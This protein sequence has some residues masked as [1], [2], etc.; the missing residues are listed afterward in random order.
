[1]H[2]GLLGSPFIN[3]VAYLLPATFSNTSGQIL[4]PSSVIISSRVSPSGTAVGLGS[5][6]AV[7][8]GF[9]V[10][11]GVGVGCGVG[12]AGVVADGLGDGVAVGT[13]V[14]VSVGVKVSVAVSV[15]RD[16]SV[17]STADGVGSAG[18]SSI[19]VGLAQATAERMTNVRAKKRFIKAD[20]SDSR[21][22]SL[23]GPGNPSN[24]A[25]FYSFFL[26]R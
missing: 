5:G 22:P 3:P 20:L 7:A 6:V 1:M 21:Y 8:V 26:F 10:T 17:G 18:C 23:S 14:T 13:G 24:H 11:V 4:T 19:D 9:G 2:N 25:L 16:V 15:G 12:V